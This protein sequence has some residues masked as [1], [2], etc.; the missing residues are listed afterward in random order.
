[1]KL[2]LRVPKSVCCVAKYI[3]LQLAILRRRCC[4][5]ALDDVVNSYVF[6][7]RVFETRGTTA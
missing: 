1:V 5:G 4:D 6:A 7:M 3:V 2:K